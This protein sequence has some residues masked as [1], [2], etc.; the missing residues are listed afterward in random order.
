[1]RTVYTVTFPPERGIEPLVASA[2]DLVDLGDQIAIHTADAL[3]HMPFA[4]QLGEEFGAIA[5]AAD[6]S[7]PIPFIITKEA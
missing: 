2:V 6:T 3:D 5:R 4:I 7:N 1:M